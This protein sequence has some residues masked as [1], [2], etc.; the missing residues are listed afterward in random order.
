[1][2]HPDLGS[3]LAQLYPDADYLRDFRVEDKGDGEGPTLTHWDETKLGPQ[4]TVD[5]IEKAANEWQ[6]G[7]A[8]RVKREKL[9]EKLSSAEFIEAYFES[10]LGNEAPMAALIER[11]KAIK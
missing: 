5:K 7:Q 3:A 9:R 8:G 1:M 4:P 11:Y 10:K 2:K 6:K